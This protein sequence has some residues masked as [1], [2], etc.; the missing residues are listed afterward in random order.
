MNGRPVPATAGH[1]KVAIEKYTQYSQMQYPR[2]CTARN[3]RG[4]PTME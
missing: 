4:P 1:V 2:T 3:A